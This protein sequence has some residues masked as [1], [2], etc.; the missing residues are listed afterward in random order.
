M[1]CGEF[2]CVALQP[3]RVRRAQDKA[4]D[5]CGGEKKPI[6]FGNDKHERQRRWLGAAT[7]EC[8]FGGG[9]GGSTGGLFTIGTG[10]AALKLS[11]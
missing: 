7:R 10:A 1:S 9:I 6:L 3:S 11:G 2:G 5:V 8:D 4:L